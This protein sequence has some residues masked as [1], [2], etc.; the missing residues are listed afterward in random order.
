MGTLSA[1]LRDYPLFDEEISQ[2]ISQ[3]ASQSNAARRYNPP[4]SKFAAQLNSE[5]LTTAS[6]GQIAE[7]AVRYRLVA[8]GYQVWKADF[9]GSRIDL[10]VNRP[11]VE[12]YIRLQ[13]KWARTEQGRPCFSLRNGEGGKIRR[14]TRVDCDF[15]VGYDL[16]TDT[17]FV[18][19]IQICEGKNSKSCDEQYAEAWDWLD[20]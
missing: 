3:R 16:E 5:E 7:A 14:F 17:A 6:K 11:G 13:V 8:L 9:E 10:L 20:S 1:L 2:R 15:V 12:K 18:V 19:P 4:K